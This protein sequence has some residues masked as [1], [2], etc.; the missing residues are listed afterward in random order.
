M[1][2]YDKH[3]KIFIKFRHRLEND[4]ELLDEIL[5]SIGIIVSE[6]NTS[7]RENRFIAGG[8]TERILAAAMRHLDFHNVRSRGLLPDEEDLVVDG[9]QFSIKAS[10]TGKRDEIRLKNTMGS[11]HSDGHRLIWTTPT[12]FVL[13][14]RGIGYADPDLLSDVAKKTG[15]AT[16]LRRR[17]LDDFH[18]AN[19]EWLIECAIPAKSQDPT[20][21]RSVSEM[22]FNEV[23]Q[24][25]D[26]GEPLFPILRANL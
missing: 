16:I 21:M 4:L 24:R 3:R 17:P 11:P 7:M 12:L 6:F 26:L 15:D 8:A 18:N 1:S 2:A 10:F 20:Q 5:K 25:T 19:P 14:N 23:I 9:I 13:A 22:V